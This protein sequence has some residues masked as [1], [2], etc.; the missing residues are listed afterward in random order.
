MISNKLH[1]KKIKKGFTLIELIIA[2]FLGSLISVSAYQMLSRI[3]KS[4]R[5]IT[6]TIENDLPIPTFYNQVERDLLGIVIPPVYKKKESQTKTEISEI[7]GTLE[8]ALEKRRGKSVVEK[9]TEFEKIDM[10]DLFVSESGDNKFFM[11]FIT[12]GGIKLIPSG[13]KDKIEP[14]IKRISYSL[15]SDPTRENQFRIVYQQSENLDLSAVQS[16]DTVN[17]YEI[18][19]NIK[20][21]KPTYWV[22]ENPSKKENEKEDAKSSDKPKLVKLDSWDPKEIEKKYNTQVPAF[23]DLELELFDYNEPEIAY[24]LNFEYN[25][26]VYF[27]QSKKSTKTEQ[28]DIKEDNLNNAG[29]KGESQDQAQRVKGESPSKTT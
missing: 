16:Q 6:G 18:I 17:K 24:K 9:K 28:E 10:K 2:L 21:V 23:I 20:S 27:A 5:D 13:G 25:I 14:L 4:A 3:Q 19:S 22:Y 26:P 8:K 1:N 29:N 7:I 12:T 15:E 11:S